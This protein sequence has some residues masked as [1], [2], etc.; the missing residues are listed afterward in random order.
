MAIIEELLSCSFP[1]STRLSVVDREGKRRDKMSL[2]LGV[3]ALYTNSKDLNR[4]LLEEV[5]DER[6]V[7]SFD[8]EE[9]VV[10][11]LEEDAKKGRDEGEVM[12]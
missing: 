11:T 5:D 8:K 7:C 10:F 2:C 12:T 4:S 1:T 3:K 6:R 9:V